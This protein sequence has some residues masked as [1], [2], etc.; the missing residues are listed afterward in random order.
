[1]FDKGA[2]KHKMGKTINIKITVD[3]DDD[4]KSDLAP[5]VKDSD[6][7]GV[8]KSTHPM[9]MGQAPAHMPAGEDFGNQVAQSLIDNSS[10]HPAAGKT[11]ESIAKE[12]AM[13][14]MD[15]KKGLKV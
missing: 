11:L 4:K 14:R 3:H 6:E 8:V 9:M 7:P 5:D 1:M 2:L 13:K 15:R 10:D 12:R